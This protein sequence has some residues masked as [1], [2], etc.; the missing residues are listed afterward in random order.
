M[1]HPDFAREVLPVV[2]SVAEYQRSQLSKVSRNSIELKSLNSLV[3]YVDKKSEE[4]LVESLQKI[5][6]EAGFITEEETVVNTKKEYNWIID[7]L[8]G[9]TNYLHQIP[10][11]AI[12][13][14][15]EHRGKII[16][17]V[18][19]EVGR[20]ECFS[21][22][23]GNGAFLNGK[24]ISVSHA[25]KLSDTLIAT[26]FPYY[27]FDR[28][29]AFLDLLKLCF[30]KTRGVRR[31]G[32]AAT[33]L[34]YTAA[35]RF[36]AFFEYGLSSWDVAAGSLIVE[37]AGGLVTDFSGGSDFL[38]GGE[39]LVVQPKIASEFTQMVRTAFLS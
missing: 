29:A 31:I 13:V 4:L 34:A 7:P 33:D 2:R 24:K 39:I 6:P 20:D 10:V 3:S 11:Y 38:F 16:F 25:E 14:A 19:H 26:G 21:A 36:D 37:E 18:V 30:Q 22:I 1:I 27:D 5:L 12:S 15:L 8:D 35:G 32:S 9:T 28:M 23:R 17:G